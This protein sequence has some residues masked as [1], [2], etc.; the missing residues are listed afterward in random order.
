MLLESLRPPLELILSWQTSQFPHGL[1]RDWGLVI[2]IGFLLS[3]SV[4][5][6][7]LRTYSRIRR[8]SFGIDDALIIFAVVS[9]SYR[10]R[11]NSC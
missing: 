6:V 4:I 3:T 1:R 2:L 10:S 5:F 7:T 9:I 8:G 11:G